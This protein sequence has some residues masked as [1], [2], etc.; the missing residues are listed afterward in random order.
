M[1]FNERSE[2][3]INEFYFHRTLIPWLRGEQSFGMRYEE[4]S[5][6]TIAQGFSLC[7][8]GQQFEFSPRSHGIIIYVWVVYY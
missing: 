7:I 1:F 5:W 6:E 2:S 8:S 4:K 3:T